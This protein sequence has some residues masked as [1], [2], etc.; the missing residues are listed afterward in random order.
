MRI[1]IAD[2][3]L[4]SRRLLERALT[5]L[6]HEVV[7]VGNG[8][9]AVLA[10]MSP[11]G[12]RLAILDWTLPGESGLEVCRLVRRR[13]APYVYLLLLT[14][15]DRREDV[16]TGL[17]AG[18]DDFLTKP[19]DAVELR[20]RLRPGERVLDLQEGLIRTQEAFRELA[21]HDSL[22]GL[23]NRRMILDQLRKEL[24]QAEREGKPL[25]VALA[26]LDDFKKVNDGLGHAAGDAVLAE[27]AKRMRSVMRDCDFIGRYGG[28]EFLLVLP[29]CD[30]DAGLLVAERVRRI[31]SDQPVLANG[32]LVPMTVSV[33]LSFSRAGGMKPEPLIRAADEAL[34][35]AKAAGRNRVAEPVRADSQA[36]AM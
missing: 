25:A 8:F 12:P 6:G 18:A 11:D 29:G 20:A 26:D 28:E 23:W 36:L 4:D 14:A 10:L 19:L 7:A 22:T 15:R 17:D 32:E 21:M 5:A 9:A 3:D 13:P 16:V 31:L 1:L 30:G 2:N 24:H 35:Q 27:A 34:Y 33:G